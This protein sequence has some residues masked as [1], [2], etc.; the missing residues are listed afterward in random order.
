MRPSRPPSASEPARGQMRMTTM[1][2]TTMKTMMKGSGTL[3]LAVVLASCGSGLN[4]SSSSSGG[5]T[6]SNTTVQIGSGSGSSFVAGS[7]A[8]SPGGQLSAGGSASVTV[9]LQYSNGTPV[10]TSTIITFISPC[11]QSGLAQFTVAGIAAPTNTVTTTTGQAVITYSA[12][13]CSG[14]DT[15]TAS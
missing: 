1:R 3:L 10:T 12:T 4:S 13:G 14:S 8:I 6:S 11:F 9:N 2:A 7:L 5:S 15:I